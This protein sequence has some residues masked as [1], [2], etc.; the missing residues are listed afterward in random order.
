METTETI[1]QEL[2][3]L[4]SKFGYPDKGI[5]AK[6]YIYTYLTDDEA[7]KILRPNNFKIPPFTVALLDDEAVLRQTKK[8]IALLQEVSSRE[9]FEILVRKIPPGGGEREVDFSSL[10][11][12]I[13][14]VRKGK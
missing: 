7:L 11:R 9:E 3:S 1:Y 8:I 13:V 2:V 4:I 6:D 14:G 12:G 5:F 10:L